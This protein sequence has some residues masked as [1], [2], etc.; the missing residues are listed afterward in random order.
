MYD[1]PR[2]RIFDFVVSSYATT[3][4]SLVADLDSPNDFHGLLAVGQYMTPGFPPLEGTTQELN[5]VTEHAATSGIPFTRLDGQL[6][7]TS[8]VLN[9]MH[10]HSWVHLACHG[11]QNSSDPTASAFHLHDGPLD[12]AAIVR[13]P[14]PHARLAFLSA[15]QTATG[16]ESM[17]EES[18]HLAAG[19]IAAGYPSVIGTMW[20]IR[21][22][23]AP[24][25]TNRVY[26]ELLKD[27]APDYKKTA[28]ALHKA[29][30]ELRQKVGEKTFV[31]WVPYIHFGV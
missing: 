2:S 21:D 26:T 22:V 11:S 17:P 7:T 28:R 29:M 8:A 30:G 10:H 18:V 24:V 31:A 20:S 25:V 14:L 5:K 27:G 12:L 4:S 23:D 16:D 15:C 13:K 19:M 6:A 3:L 9:A 1:V